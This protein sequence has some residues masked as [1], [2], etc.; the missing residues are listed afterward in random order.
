MDERTFV[1]D[2]FYPL[3]AA[4]ALQVA[5]EA[6]FDLCAHI[7]AY[8]GW[9]LPKS[10]REIV[11][12]ALEHGLL[13][14]GLRDSYLQ[15]ARFRNRLVHLYDHVEERE[16]L[17]FIKDHVGDFAPLVATVVRRYLPEPANPADLEDI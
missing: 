4:R 16:L 14:P 6:S 3:A 10:Y 17:Q 11:L 2:S 1:E 5:L 15:M 12:V 7:I 13:P 9:G 8:E